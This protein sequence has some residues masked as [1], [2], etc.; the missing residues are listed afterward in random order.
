M[1]GG[2]QQAHGQC[3]A[4]T[5]DCCH[6][7]A[8]QDQDEVCGRWPGSAVRG[9][10]PETEL[11]TQVFHGPLLLRGVL[12]PDRFALLLFAEVVGPTLVTHGW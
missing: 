4:R 3:P 8:R 1:R 5:S 2:L 12:L 7:G 10:P 9:N 6:K 11:C